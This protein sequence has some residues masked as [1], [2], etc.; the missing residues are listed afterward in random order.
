MSPTL[1]AFLRSWP[2]EPWLL[3]SLLMPAGVYWRGYRVLRRRD[4]GRWHA[5]RPVS[6]AAGILWFIAI[7]ST[8]L[9]VIAPPA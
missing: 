6:K 2:F 1:D 5:G 9:R 8:K 7:S 4:P 3:L